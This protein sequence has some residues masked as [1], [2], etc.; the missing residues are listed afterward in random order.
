LK[1]HL[2]Y[3]S[4][5]KSQQ[6]HKIVGFKVYYFCMIERY[7][8]IPLTSG[9]GSGRPK[10]TW[11]RW[12]RIRIQIWNTGLEKPWRLSELSRG[13]A[14]LTLSTKCCR[15]VCRLAFAGKLLFQVELDPRKKDFFKISTTRFNVDYLQINMVQEASCWGWGG[16]G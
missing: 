16:G 13:V 7:G 3:F 9:S 1:V 6:C 15:T 8:S 12:L 14:I 2:H 5:I 11:I 10:N 4:K